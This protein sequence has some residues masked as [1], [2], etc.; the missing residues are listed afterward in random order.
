MPR[1]PL[2]SAWTDEETAHL[3][4]LI[5]KQY[6]ITRIARRLGRSSETVAKKAAENGVTLPPPIKRGR[7]KGALSDGQSQ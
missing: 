1:I 4:R 3:K 7:S 5:A 2:H 6:P